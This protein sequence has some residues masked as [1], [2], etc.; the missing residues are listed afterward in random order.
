MAFSKYEIKFFVHE[1]HGVDGLFS[2]IIEGVRI[3]RAFRGRLGINGFI[4]SLSQFTF[5]NQS[6]MQANLAD[7]Q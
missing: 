3:I 4:D 6:A 7:G 2:Y 1:F 5:C